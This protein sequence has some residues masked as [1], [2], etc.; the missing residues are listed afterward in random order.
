MVET[1]HLVPFCIRPAVSLVLV[2][3][4]VRLL[5]LLSGIEGLMLILRVAIVGVAAVLVLEA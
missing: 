1:P 3:P 4:V 2:A 5:R